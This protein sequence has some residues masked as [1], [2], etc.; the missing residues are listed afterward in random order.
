MLGGGERWIRVGKALTKQQ[1]NGRFY[2]FVPVSPQCLTGRQ[3]LFRPQFWIR[4]HRDTKASRVWSKPCTWAV[5]E[6]LM[7]SLVPGLFGRGGRVI[8]RVKERAQNH[9]PEKM[10][11]ALMPQCQLETPIIPLEALSLCQAGV[12]WDAGGAL[13][14]SL[15]FALLTSFPA[16]VPG[17]SQPKMS[18]IWRDYFKFI[19]SPQSFLAF[20]VFKQLFSVSSRSQWHSRSQ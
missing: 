10:A 14:H 16:S 2:K 12:I 7:G 13:N 18:H 6:A 17:Q 8:G 5:P 4:Q 11:T 9:S 3:E 20:N 15:A 1:Q 19:F